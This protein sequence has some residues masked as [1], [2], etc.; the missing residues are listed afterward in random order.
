MITFEMVFCNSMDVVSEKHLSMAL[1]CMGGQAIL[2]RV[3]N[4]QHLFMAR[5][6]NTGSFF[7]ASNLQHV[8]A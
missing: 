3:T 7:S 6:C 2:E 4:V 5:A 1:V 8:M